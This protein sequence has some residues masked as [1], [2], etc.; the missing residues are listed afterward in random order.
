MKLESPIYLILNHTQERLTPPLLPRAAFHLDHQPLTSSPTSPRIGPPERIQR[1][2]EY[3]VHPWT[4]PATLCACLAS[5]LVAVRAALLLFFFSCAYIPSRQTFAA[6][7]C[8]SVGS[9]MRVRP[10]IRPFVL[11][12]LAAVG[13]LA[14]CLPSSFELAAKQA[15]IADPDFVLV[16][17]DFVV[18]EG[19]SNAFGRAVTYRV[20]SYAS[21]W[22]N[23]EVGLI[24]VLTTPSV[25]AMSVEAN[26]V[27]RM[28]P[29]ELLDR[30]LKAV[31]E[32]EELEHRSGADLD[33]SLAVAHEEFARLPT[34]I[35][36]L[37]GSRFEL[38]ADERELTAWVVQGRHQ[39]D[40]IVVGILLDGHV[41]VDDEAMDDVL[42]ALATLDHPVAAA[43]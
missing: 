20:D 16:F 9:L 28:T 26:P 6:L 25:N 8:E 4:Q 42:Q 21:V 30:I 15:Y 41:D 43:E 18:E 33:V 29:R 24:A 34:G 7:T 12:L 19:E 37:E 23:E 5:P 39:E 27:A 38:S 31:R 36:N 1:S 10:T 17:E 35:G 32:E 14:G 3:P 13:V 22:W 11:V 2:P 40:F